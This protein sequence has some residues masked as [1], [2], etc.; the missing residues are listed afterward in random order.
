[1]LTRYEPWSAVRQLQNEMNRAFGQALNDTDDGSNVVTSGWMPAVDIREEN[2]HFEICADVPGVDPEDIDVT[3]ENGVLTIKG[4]RKMK[5]TTDGDKGYRRVE[6]AY[7]TFYRRFGLPDTADAENISAKG[8]NGV[9][10]VVIPKK[11]QIK[12]KRITVAS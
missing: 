5:S 4:E 1:M 6:R 8:K 12:P 3:M 9:L 7:G 2:E 10:E 11:S